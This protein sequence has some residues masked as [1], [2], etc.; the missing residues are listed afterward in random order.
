MTASEV[1][2]E[3]EAGQEQALVVMT[4]SGPAGHGVHIIIG[5]ISWPVAHDV[6]ATRSRLL[7]SDD[8]I[9]HR[10]LSR[11]GMEEQERN[12]STASQGL[13]ETAWLQEKSTSN[14][15]TTAAL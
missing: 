14:P 9:R 6:C 15:V 1:L 13:Q 5:E 11:T 2:P 3:A 4:S 10:R 12:G 8:A 7:E